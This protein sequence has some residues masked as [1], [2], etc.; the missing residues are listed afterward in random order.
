M[1][2]TLRRG[3]VPAFYAHIIGRPINPTVITFAPMLAKAGVREATLPQILVD[4]PR[5]FS[6]SRP[7][8]RSFFG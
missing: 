3:S 6:Q 2:S 5:S 1:D 8:S 4:N 7:R